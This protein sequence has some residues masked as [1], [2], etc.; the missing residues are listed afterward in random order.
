MYTL[1]MAM[2]VGF[3]MNIGK[4]HLLISQPGFGLNAT[5]ADLM[6]STCISCSVV[7]DK[8]VY[9]LPTLCFIAD[10]K[11]YI[12]VQQIGGFVV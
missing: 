4:T 7:Q 1:F 12:L 6:D 9:W 5:G 11:I 3:S 10:N 2:V 8:S